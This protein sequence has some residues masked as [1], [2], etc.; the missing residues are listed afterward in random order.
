ERRAGQA[1]V[2]GPAALDG[3]RRLGRRGADRRGLADL[4]TGRPRP[5]RLDTAVRDERHAD[6]RVDHAGRVVRHARVGGG[7]VAADAHR[8]AQ[9][10][11]GAAR[12]ARRAP[13]GAR[14]PGCGRGRHDDRPGRVRRVTRRRRGRS[15]RR[16]ARGG[17]RAPAGDRRRR[18]RL[19]LRPAHR[20]DGRRHRHLVR[21]CL[22]ARGVH[23]P[24]PRARGVD[25]RAGDGRSSG[26]DRRERGGGAHARRRT[27]RDARLDA[28]HPRSGVA[29]A[30][31]RRPEV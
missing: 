25:L 16:G 5:V 14:L 2:P 7:H 17:G 21:V 28:H 3:C 22:R 10:E 18:R 24:D 19:W 8:R 29:T 30:A 13:A 26:A 1:P 9:P 23:L 11:R 6:H 4:L 31:A 27:A 12:E 15:G 20:L